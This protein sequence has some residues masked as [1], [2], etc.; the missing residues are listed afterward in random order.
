[1]TSGQSKQ[2]QAANSNS[3]TAWPDQ[4]HFTQALQNPHVA[5]IG[6]S[7]KGGQV[8]ANRPGLPLMWSGR[9]ATVYK[10]KIGDSYSA[11]R[12]FNSPVTD[13][14][15]RYTRLSNFLS[16]F[17]PRFLVGFE[18]L[19]EGILVGASRYPLVK[20]DFV[21]GKNLNKFIGEVIDNHQNHMGI[22]EDVADRWMA[23]NGALRNLRIAHNDLQH[24]N[25]MIQPNRAIRLVDYD[26][27]FLPDSGGDTPEGGQP[28]YQHPKRRSSDYN[29]HVDNFPAFVI[30]LSLLAIEQDPTLWRYSGDQ[31][32]LFM[33]DDFKDPVGS[34]RFL[35]LKRSKDKTV[36]VLTSYL[37][38]YCAVP[39]ELV[40]NLEIVT[41]AENAGQ[42]D[43]PLAD[44][45][46]SS[47][48]T[49]TTASRPVSPSAPPPQP[50]TGQ[51][52]APA[53]PVQNPPAGQGTRATPSGTVNPAS[54]TRLRQAQPANPGVA[55]PA[56]QVSPATGPTVV[57]GQQATTPR[58]QLGG[59]LSSTAVGT[60]NCSRGHPND[61][62]LIYC[63]IEQCAAVLYAGTSKC[64]GCNFVY[65]QNAR[66][67][68]QCAN[69]LN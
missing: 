61:A 31:N 35:E 19:D 8:E 68:P 41:S 54:V 66:F 67:C 51:I 21:E 18:Y 39:V 48:S 28:N 12:C 2:T 27:F 20:M 4:T 52:Q 17:L 55:L 26:S 37:E 65:P 50:P 10:I 49:R 9:F 63:E 30:Y 56:Q 16:S 23:I 29:E 15:D 58:T 22:L 44:G 1:M 25:V 57:I 11:I 40:P 3:K 36:R 59:A 6:D 24:G 60:I 34:E 69:E 13:Q 38:Q 53:A 62:T 42:A 5:L 46:S 7:V 14:R 64:S 45:T 32:I 43:A 47:G 33:E